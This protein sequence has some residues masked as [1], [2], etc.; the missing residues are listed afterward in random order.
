M[1]ES[2]NEFQGCDRELGLSP[3]PRKAPDKSGNEEMT[4]ELLSCTID[5][6]RRE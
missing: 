5:D 2:M 4:G 6:L 1:N 3:A